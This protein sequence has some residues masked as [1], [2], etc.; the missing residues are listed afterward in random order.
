MLIIMIEASEFFIFCFLNLVFIYC[1][2]YDIR[3]RKIPNKAFIYFFASSLIFSIPYIALRLDY[4]FIIILFKFVI[5]SLIL[6]LAYFLFYMKIIGG[7][8]GKMILLIFLTNSPSS[9]NYFKIFFFFLIFLTY[10]LILVLMKFIFNH[11]NGQINMYKFYFITKKIDSKFERFFMCSYYKF[12]NFSKLN[13]NFDTKCILRDNSLF[14]NT[15][16]EKI[17]VFAQFRP[18][19]LL[20]IYFVY[21][22]YLFAL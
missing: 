15:K 8:D 16:N 11:L 2:Y 22:S 10:Y 14:Y 7:S 18:P 19:L 5:F 20:L 6:F 4:L 17:Q 21:I 1:I 9:S 12:V 13:K 3:L